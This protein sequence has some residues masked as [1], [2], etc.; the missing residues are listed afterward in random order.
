MKIK[1]IGIYP[2]VMFWGKKFKRGKI[3][4]IPGVAKRKLPF[5]FKIVGKSEDSKKYTI[6]ELK[7][8]KQRLGWRE[9][10]RWAYDVFGVKDTSED[11]LYEEILK[12]QGD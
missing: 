4:E 5:D 10:Q 3:V 2:E 1:Y 9:F 7:E 8:I 12:K 11:E 6:H